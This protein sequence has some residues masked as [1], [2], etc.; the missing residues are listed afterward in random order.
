MVGLYV[1]G[2]VQVPSGSPTSGFRARAARRVGEGVVAGEVGDGGAV[3]V[4]VAITEVCVRV[5]VVVAVLC[6]LL[7]LNWEVMETLKP[8]ID[9]GII[10]GIRKELG[11]FL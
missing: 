11:I 4:W 2:P 1:E 5:M 6:K 8:E 9:K 7:G 10:E 3:M